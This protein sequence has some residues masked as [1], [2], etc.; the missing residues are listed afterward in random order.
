MFHIADSVNTAM[1][2]TSDIVTTPLSKQYY[3]MAQ[4]NTTDFVTML[5]TVMNIS[6]Q[7]NH[8]AA[9]YIPV[10][11]DG[12]DMITFLKLYF[13]PILL[14]VGTLGNILSFVV[15]SRLALKQSA[16]AFYFRVLAVADT[17]ALNVGL[18][19]NWMRDAF[20][21]HIYPITDLS[22]RIQTYLRY[23]LPDCAV[24]VLVILTLERMVGV[25]WPHRVH[26]IFTR[27]RTRISVLIMVLVIV[28]VNIPAIWITTKN[29]GDTSVHPCTVDIIVLAYVIWPWIDLTIYSLL[30]FLMMITS[31]IIMLKTI[32]RRR[33]MLCRQGSINSNMGRT[34]QTMTATLLTVVFVFL[35]LTAP[36]VIYATILKELYGKINIDFHLFY[37]VASYL[38]YVNNSVNFFLYCISG[39]NFRTELKYLFLGRKRR[40]SRFSSSGTDFSNIASGRSTMRSISVDNVRCNGVDFKGSNDKIR[41]GSPVGSPVFMEMKIPAYC[42]QDP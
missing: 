23:M 25:Q 12:L 36:F 4:Q 30:P 14:F 6:E 37:F 39:R 13:A 28:T 31:V 15:F 34:V 42:G 24:W 27:R 35:L 32:K 2:V 1:D 38:R 7:D 3:E 5:T 29:L 33:R 40:L 22:C 26:D 16:T 20:D 19:P 41:V 11:S 17:L 18:W 8:T 10:I 9:P 21:I